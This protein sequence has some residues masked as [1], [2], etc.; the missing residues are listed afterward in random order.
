MSGILKANVVT[1]RLH[2][3]QPNEIEQAI[4]IYESGLSLAKVS[5]ALLYDTTTIWREFKRLKVQLR[6]SRGKIRSDD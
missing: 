4:R 1:I 3:M 5:E 6:D 2:S